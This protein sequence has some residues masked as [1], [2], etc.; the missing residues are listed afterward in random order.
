MTEE[1]ACEQ[2]EPPPQHGGGI[3]IFLRN[4]RKDTPPSSGL[5]RDRELIKLAIMGALDGADFVDKPC[6]LFS[7]F[8]PS[9][10]P[11]RPGLVFV[12]VSARRSGSNPWCNAV[13]TPVGHN[14]TPVCHSLPLIRWTSCLRVV[15][16]SSCTRAIM[17]TV[18]GGRPSAYTATVYSYNA[19]L[20]SIRRP[21]RGLMIG[22]DCLANMGEPQ[23]NHPSP[24]R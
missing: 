14:R 7:P 21:S 20:R 1:G 19:R 9:P 5:I 6:L 11:S 2:G 12:A 18:V 3:G 4:G 15:A 10:F 24:W 16:T 8:P 22:L 17:Y 13:R 23:I